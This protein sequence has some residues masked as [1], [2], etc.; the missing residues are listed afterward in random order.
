[1]SFRWFVFTVAAL[2]FINVSLAIFASVLDIGVAIYFTSTIHDCDISN[3]IPCYCDAT[4]E[5]FRR[6]FREWGSYECN[7]VITR[8]P[9]NL[10][11]NAVLTL[12]C[13]L[14]LL[15]YLGIF[16]WVLRNDTP[17]VQ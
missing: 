3:G 9:G 15:A 1:M 16:L 7:N 17:I 12:A 14:L 5:E 13:A 8:N 2:R 4:E 6:T 11:A 10:V